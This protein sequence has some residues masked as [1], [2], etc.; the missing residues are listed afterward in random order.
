VRALIVDDSRA[1][2]TIL[3]QILRSLGFEVVEAGNGQEGLAKLAEVSSVDLAMVDWNMPV[4]DGLAFVQAARALATHDPMRIVMVTTETDMDRMVRAIKEGA[5]EYIMKPFTRD[6]V[7]QKL[8]IVGMTV[9][10]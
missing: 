9:S 10:S 1:I 3:G 8:E 6:M 5:N 4:M 2:R 7:V